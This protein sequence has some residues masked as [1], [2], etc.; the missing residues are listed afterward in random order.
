MHHLMVCI[1]LAA[2]LTFKFPT[3]HIL[4]LYAIINIFVGDPVLIHTH[5]MLCLVL[6]VYLH[7]WTLDARLHYSMRLHRSD[8]D[9]NL[10]NISGWWFGTFFFPYIRNNHP[11]CYSLHHFSEG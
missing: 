8:N 3:A 1:H 9:V 5:F 6:E 7:F 10:C 11:N 2:G 4:R